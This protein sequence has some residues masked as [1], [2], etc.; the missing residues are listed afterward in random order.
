MFLEQAVEAS[1]VQ[2][3]NGLIKTKQSWECQDPS[4]Y[5]IWAPKNAEIPSSSNG[6]S[7]KVN[8]ASRTLVWWDTETCPPPYTECNAWDG[9]ADHL[10]RMLALPTMNRHETV[11]CIAY[12]G[13]EVS[14][15]LFL[16]LSRRGII[17]Q[18]RI[19]PT[20]S[21]PGMLLLSC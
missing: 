1:V 18:R 16:A 3:C 7:E 4:D 2:C 19:L 14:E 11:T 9:I 10:V 12:G 6:V 5:T 20:C 13:G 17:V 15:P 8:S 21:I